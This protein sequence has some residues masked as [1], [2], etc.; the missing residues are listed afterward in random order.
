MSEEYRHTDFTD[1]I[2]AADC[3]RNICIAYENS[4][5]LLAVV[6]CLG[7]VV[8]GGMSWWGLLL[9]LP[10]LYGFLDALWSWWKARQVFYAMKQPIYRAFEDL[11]EAQFYSQAQMELWE[12]NLMGLFGPDKVKIKELEHDT[13]GF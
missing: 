13:V 5:R 6:L 10:I 3:Y 12:I 4:T 1:M 2:H 7:I 11:K 8:L 9:L